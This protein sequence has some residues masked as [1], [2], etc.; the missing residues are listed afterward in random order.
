M[1]E[2]ADAGDLCYEPSGQTDNSIGLAPDEDAADE[3]DVDLLNLPFHQRWA[4]VGSRSAPSTPVSSSQNLRGSVTFSR[5]A[6][7]FKLNTTHR[8]PFNNPEMTALFEPEAMQ[9]KQ[10]LRDG[11]NESGSA[12]RFLKSAMSMPGF[13]RTRVDRGDCVLD[14]DKGMAEYRYGCISKNLKRG[15]LASMSLGL[16]IEQRRTRDVEEMGKKWRQG[17]RQDSRGQRAALAEFS[18]WCANNFGDSKSAWAYLDQ[19]GKHNV[20]KNEFLAQLQ[21]CKYPTGTLG[22]N[23]VFFFLDSDD[24]EIVHEEEF[25]SSLGSAPDLQKKPFASNATSQE[26]DPIEAR[27]VAEAGPNALDAKATLIERVRKLDHV[28]AQL[29]EFMLCAFPTLQMAFRRMDVNGGGSISK[30]E[31]QETMKTLQCKAGSKPVQLHVRDLFSRLDVTNS[32]FLN[33][34]EIVQNIQSADPMLQRLKDWAS[35]GVPNAQHGRAEVFKETDLRNGLMKCFRVVDGKDRIHC[36]DFLEGLSRLRYHEWHINDLWHR[37]DKDSSG[38]LTL[39]EFTAFI[40]KD[41]PSKPI[42]SAPVVPLG[43]DERRRKLESAHS[44][45]CQ[46]AKLSLSEVLTSQRLMA[47]RQKEQRRKTAWVSAPSLTGSPT[48]LNRPDFLRTVQAGIKGGSSE[49]RHRGRH[50]L[51]VSSEPSLDL[52]GG[53]CALR[54][55]MVTRMDE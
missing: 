55:F 29:M 46:S 20:H 8:T 25:L 44:G 16:P 47:S 7:S 49:L 26:M 52:C 11:T 19:L 45:M 23:N 43:T 24:D 54:S 28:V 53:R 21:Q 50:V 36:V 17:Q 34:D 33:L 2:D 39:G 12:N 48:G 37:L 30:G 31:F 22:I 40:C 9:T 32:G 51:T 3:L 1:A 42:K 10:K 38:E 18:R 27:A 35:I 6:S 41:P 5:V 14:L 15:R 13:A 4:V